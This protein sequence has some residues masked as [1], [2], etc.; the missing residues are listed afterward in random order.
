MF[1][2]FLKQLLHK[3]SKN[4]PKRFPQYQI[5][6]GTYGP[7]LEV[8]RQKDGATLTIGA[9]CSIAAGVKIILGG[10]HRMDWVTTYPFSV[11]WPAGQKTQGHPK[12]SGNVTIG[13][14]V[15]IGKDAV[16][17]SGVTIGDGAVVGARAVVADDILPYAVV[18]GNPARMVKKR[19]NEE[20]IRRL[21]QTKWWDWHD[22]QIEKTL[23]LLLNSDIEAFLKVAIK[24]NNT[25]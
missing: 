5:G 23:P 25:F 16:I 3:K 8:L 4:L 11:F 24:H 9:F 7:D 6:R 19:F 18:V 2:T 22:D 1:R 12:T 21:L 13:N 20:T 17:L 10:D 15:W 14:D